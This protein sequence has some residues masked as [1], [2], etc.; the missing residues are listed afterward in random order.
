MTPAYCSNFYTFVQCRNFTTEFGARC[1]PCNNHGRG[2]AMK[3]D[4]LSRRG[5]VFS[6]VDSENESDDSWSNIQMLNA[7]N[8][9]QHTAQED[10]AR[11]RVA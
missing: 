2:R 1:G 3:E 11:A 8:L 9:S 4:G 5:S 6:D 10:K 7:Q